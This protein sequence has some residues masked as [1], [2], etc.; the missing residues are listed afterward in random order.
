M[1]DAAATTRADIERL[2]QSFYADVIADD[3]LGPIFTPLVGAHWPAHR[4][5]MVEFWCTVLLHTRSFR[6]NVL[7]KHVDLLPRLRP[8]HFARW[9]TLWVRHTSQHLNAADAA[10]LQATASGIARNLYL[11]CFGTVPRFERH[12]TLV[13]LVT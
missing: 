5:R 13:R 9:L 7:Q 10:E 8:E 2:V 4:A 6:G 12:G 1:S 3:A 11:G